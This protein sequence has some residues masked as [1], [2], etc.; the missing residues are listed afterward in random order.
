MSHLMDDLCTLK[1]RLLAFSNSKAARVC[2]IA[3]CSPG[4][5][6][7]PLCVLPAPIDA[8]NEVVAHVHRGYC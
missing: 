6:G 5:A 3:P 7:L 1:R 2:E 8:T 4:P